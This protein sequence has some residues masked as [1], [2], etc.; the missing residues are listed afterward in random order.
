MIPSHEQHYA[1]FAPFLK[2]VTGMVASFS[3]VAISYMAHVEAFLRLTGVALG[4]LCGI[5]SLISIVR[6]MPSRK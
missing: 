3:G 5:A 6:N 2:G 4:C 1:T